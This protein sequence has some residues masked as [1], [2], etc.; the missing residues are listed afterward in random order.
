[1][2]THRLPIE[3]IADGYAALR[4]EPDRTLKVVLSWT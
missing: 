2:I 3:Q 1:M 4:E